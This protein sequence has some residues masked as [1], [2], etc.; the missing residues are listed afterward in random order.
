MS[1]EKWLRDG[2]AAAV[3][4]PPNNP[5]RARAAT[6]LARR[7]RR[8]TALAAVGTAG[9]VAVA[10]V[11]SG[12]LVGGTSDAPPDG[13]VADG[14]PLACPPAPKDSSATDELDQPD[15]GLPGGV[16]DGAT[17]AR[18]CP[19]GGLPMQMPAD[20][21]TTDVDEL[22]AAV[23]GLD[24][25]ESD[26][27]RVCTS[28]LGPGYR[29][30]FGYPDGSTFLISAGFYGCHSVV[31]GDGYRDAPEVPLQ[32]FQDLVAAQRSAQ[33]PPTPPVDTDLDCQEPGLSPDVTPL[34]SADDLTEAVVCVAGPNG[35]TIRSITIPREDLRALVAD[36]DENAYR[37]DGV[38]GCFKP[39][40][41]IIGAT[42]WGDRVT[43]TY[44]CNVY[45]LSDGTAWDP[46]TPA[47]AVID[48]LSR[49]ARR[50]R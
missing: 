7:R 48:R 27:E 15:P 11:L 45:L 31:V 44:A 36:I 34:G 32:E 41:W 1:D 24:R 12:V 46:S 23:N 30:L 47:Q 25:Q 21:L 19:G 13:I 20:L 40:P 16:P 6:N 8:T 33:E 5:D 14:S 17:S 3:P 29:I 26:G 49:E 39:A 22:V 38:D 2:L 50:V 35:R 18:M 28:D 42:A 37:A 4:E 9:A 10:A 43:I